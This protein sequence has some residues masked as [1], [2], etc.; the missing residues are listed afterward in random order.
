M[1]RTNAAVAGY[2]ASPLNATPIAPLTSATRQ[3]L[4]TVTPQIEGSPIEAPPIVQ[5]ALASPGRP[6]ENTTRLF[7]E[8]RWERDFSAVRLHTDNVAAES[9]R[10]LS[11]RAYTVGSNIVFAA[12][13]YAPATNTGRRLIAHELAHVLQ[14]ATSGTRVSRRPTPVRVAPTPPRA[15]P[16]L[17]SPRVGTEPAVPDTGARYLP[18]PGD[19]SLEAILER[20]RLQAI[21]ERNVEQ[22]ERPAAVLS[23]GGS[24][25]DFVEIWG[26]HSAMD[27]DGQQFSYRSRVFH[28][29]DA[30]VWRV[31]G[32]QTTRDLLRILW[33]LDPAIVPRLLPGNRSAAPLPLGPDPD[34]P[35]FPTNVD[36]TGTIR[37]AVFLQAVAT[38]GI[39]LPDPRTS[40]IPLVKVE[41]LMNPV[42]ERREGAC[43]V[44]SVPRAGGHPPHDSYA[45]A[46]T[47][48]K[49]DY[50]IRSPEGLDCQTDGI[51]K[52]GI[53]WE[54]KTGHKILTEM[55]VASVSPEVL[56]QI[57]DRIEE[58][59]VRCLYATSRC[60]Y[61]Y[62][63][64]FADPSVRDFFGA[65]WNGR[66]PVYCRSQ[67]GA[68]C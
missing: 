34:A 61:R 62:R 16:V 60:G 41:S 13:E 50:L 66:P 22:L 20:A 51:D 21:R 12:G 44:A 57:A 33:E 47:G 58:Q 30:I 56:H 27:A 6:L 49:L 29:L 37:F 9:A 67:T 48:S 65:L 43:D 32:A 24:S 64:A 38:R 23:R 11:A 26:R 45:T 7:F 40:V 1:K 14:Q 46:V 8:T 28:V 25:P 39:Q 5:Q 54:V 35:I 10:A 19:T 55:R 59:R 15:P 42:P 17:L 36:P 31:S 68:P 2:R 18:A 63:Y 4:D 53:T 3:S 52:N